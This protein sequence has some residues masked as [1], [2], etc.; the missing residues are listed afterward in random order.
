MPKNNSETTLDKYGCCP[1]CGAN[2]DNGSIFD[3]LRAQTYYDAKTDDEL[4]ALIEE[5]YSPP[6]RFSR[7]IGV[8][9]PLNHPQHYDG[10]SLWRCPDCNHEWNRFHDQHSISRR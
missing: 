6:H 8:E 2:W 5:S 4:R 10:V 7:L 9:L 1:V 3:A